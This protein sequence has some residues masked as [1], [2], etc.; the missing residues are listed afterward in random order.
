MYTIF[1]G[2]QNKQ[3][4]KGKKRDLKKDANDEKDSV[5]VVLEP[6]DA[7]IWQG[8]LHYRW[9]D[10]GGGTWKTFSQAFSSYLRERMERMIGLGL[11]F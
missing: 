1:K 4:V 6:G 3:P 10:G 5:R 7:L 8:G 2:S 9:S 11:G